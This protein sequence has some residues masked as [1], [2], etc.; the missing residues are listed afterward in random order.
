VRDQNRRTAWMKNDCKRACDKWSV[1]CSGCEARKA[2][3]QMKSDGKQT[4][5]TWSVSCK[6]RRLGRQPTHKQSKKK[7]ICGIGL[8]RSE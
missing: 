1:S 5:Y 6:A 2:A 4:C 8:F 7:R 3:V